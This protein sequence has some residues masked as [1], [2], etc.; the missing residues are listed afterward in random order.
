MGY[1]GMTLSVIP[2]PRF[3]AMIA[4]LPTSNECV[5]FGGKTT[6][7]TF[8]NTSIVSY[9]GILGDT[10]TWTGTSWINIS[11]GF[12]GNV[13]N[14]PSPR[15]DGAISYDGTYVTLVGGSTTIGNR[16]GNLSDTWSYSTVSGWQQQTLN[17]YIIPP[18]GGQYSIPT[19]LA[20]AKLAYISGASE[21]VLV[22]GVADQQNS[23]YCLDTWTWVTAAPASGGA[24]TQLSPPNNYVGVK[25]PGWASNGT[26][27]VMFGG[28]NYNGATA[29]VYHWTGSTFTQITGFVPGY[30]CPSARYGHNFIY[31]ASQGL[32]ICYGGIQLNGQY[33][34]DTW[35]YNSGT[36][37]WSNITP[38]VSPSPRAFSAMAYNSHTTNS[39]LF[40]GLAD[41]NSYLADTWVLTGSTWVAQ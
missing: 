26:I 17:E 12:T 20:G 22:G 2:P 34:G 4:E 39:V 29:N 30:T 38:T 37:T 16:T 5:L 9:G 32:F 31:D 35:T 28:L 40:S 15:Y 33:A 21:A 25:Y 3:N 8:T 7:S 23:K 14:S 19:T 36:M 10:W 6:A 11:P 27:G 41:R 18:N 24:W 13:V 1:F